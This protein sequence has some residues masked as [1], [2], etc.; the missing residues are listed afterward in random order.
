MRKAE[1]LLNKY[2]AGTATDEEKAW[3]ES[4]YLKQGTDGPSLTPDQLEE[5][6]TLAYK[7]LQK[8]IRSGRVQPLRSRIA[9]AAVLMAL[10]SIGLYIWRSSDLTTPENVVLLTA[11]I[12]PGGNRA[13]LSLS[14]GRI[15]Q[16]SERQAGIT[17]DE[18]AIRYSDGAALPEQLT[19]TASAVLSV[20]QGGQYQITLADGSKVWLNAG[21]T[22]SYPIRFD[23]SERIVELQ[24][25][26]YFEVA[27]RQQPFL[28][29]SKDQVIEVLGTRFNVNA[30]SDESLAKTTLQSGSIQIRVSETNQEALLSPNQQAV[31]SG[32]TLQIATVDPLEAIAWKEGFFVFDNIRLEDAMTQI[33]RWYNVDIHFENEER[34]A[35]RFSGSL[36]KYVQVSQVLGKL[37]LTG[38]A[39]FEVKDRQIIIK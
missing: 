7:R 2:Q 14:D 1:D 23:Q 27:H 21:S 28:V 34:R 25:E 20:P 19:E 12:P 18:Q 29:K 15:I 24:G 6:H 9:I 13:T 32:Q 5:E 4:W 36:S 38:S 17:V 31:L 26:A 11:D 16:L 37:A 8:Q 3:V 30:Y 39:R 33:S 22:L 35:E 10:L